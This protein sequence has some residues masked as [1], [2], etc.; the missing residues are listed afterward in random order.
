MYICAFLFGL[1]VA[2]IQSMEP[3]E[4]INYTKKSIIKE[5]KVGDSFSSKD[6]GIE[7]SNSYS[8]NRGNRFKTEGSKPTVSNHVELKCAEIISQAKRT[9]IRFN[10]VNDPCE[11]IDIQNY[12]EIALI[13]PIEKN[14]YKTSSNKAILIT[15]IQSD[16][17]YGLAAIQTLLGVFEKNKEL[18]P[19]RTYF[20]LTDVN[21]V[22]ENYVINFYQKLGFGIINNS[23]KAPTHNC[24]YLSM[25]FRPRFCTFEVL[26]P[27]WE[28]HG[29][30]EKKGS[31]YYKNDYIKKILK[32]D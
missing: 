14:F 8:N 9:F 13:N 32:S 1:S 21:S 26:D 11:N 15:D 25:L 30:I 3:E 19:E 29:S 6:L 31:V 23:D 24:T 20:M 12:L 2:S 7:I 17:G 27:A 28:R 4:N 18:Y 5:F 16:S 22:N 10:I